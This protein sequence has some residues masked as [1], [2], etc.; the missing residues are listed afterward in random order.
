M[1]QRYVLLAFLLILLALCTA[2]Y[3]IGRA[4]LPAATPGPASRVPWTPPG[5]TATVETNP[6]P[7]AAAG[8]PST[9]S[10]TRAPTAT[11][12]GVATPRGLAGGSPTPTD[13][14]TPID[15]PTVTPTA[16][17]PA[18]YRYEPAGAVRHSSGDCPGI[19]ILGTVTD[20]QGRPLADVR[21][22][23]TD[24]YGNTDVKTTKSVANDV[25]RYDFPIF[26]PAR[27]F[28]LSIIGAQGEPLSP[29]V[30][31]P[32]GLDPVAQATCHHVNWKER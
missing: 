28:Y 16:T 14:P 1:N 19:Y 25:G 4:L 15:T 17:L 18:A 30:E 32:H 13:W 22:K 12:A 23:L 21:L 2:A 10:P 20:R 8:R 3:L 24:E 9:T 6:S 27:R 7:T 11:A 5:I 26:G 29:T 31:I